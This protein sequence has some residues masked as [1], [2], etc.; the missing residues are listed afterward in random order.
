MSPNKD[1]IITVGL[2]MKQ[3]PFHI[4]LCFSEEGEHMADLFYS[5]CTGVFASSVKFIK[6]WGFL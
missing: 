6:P 5:P 1:N 2:D 4:P 3:V